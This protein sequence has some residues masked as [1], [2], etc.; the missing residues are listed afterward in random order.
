M[1]SVLEI[2]KAFYSDFISVRKAGRPSLQ[3]SNKKKINNLF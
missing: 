1:I 2:S 3:Q